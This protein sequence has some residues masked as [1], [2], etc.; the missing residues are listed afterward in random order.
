M[1]ATSTPV[2]EATLP[3]QTARR[4]L[5]RAFAAAGLDTAEL[6]ARLIL[7]AGLAIDHASLVRDPDLPI[8]AG[9]IAITTFCARRLAREPVSRILGRREFWGL[10]FT[11]NPAVL[12]PRPD[13]ETLIETALDLLRDRREEALRLLDLG[14]G[15]GA[16]LAALLTTFPRATGYGIEIS[17]AAAATAQTNLVRL[18]LAGRGGVI[19]GDWTSALRGSFDLIVSNPPYIAGS[20]IAELAPEVSAHDP[21]LAL[22]GGP[23]GLAVYRLLAPAVVP[24]L[25]PRG[26]VAFE[27]G[28]AQ[29]H[30]LGTLL[31]AAGFSSLGARRDLA[32]HERVVAAN[33]PD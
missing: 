19:C 3:R 7:C 11:I 15:S 23:D 4:R 17:P 12:D 18:G 24:L 20:E 16:I 5:A 22:D 10:E 9:S 26:Y 8:G 25:A 21:H 13:T 32:G 30:D 27:C 6:D 31:E 2:F 33:W 29:A 14:T 1:T 28:S